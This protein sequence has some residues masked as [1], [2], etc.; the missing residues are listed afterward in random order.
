MAWFVRESRAERI[1]DK[2]ELYKKLEAWEK[3][4]EAIISGLIDEYIQRHRETAELLSRPEWVEV[5]CNG[6]KEVATGL[7]GKMLD[8]LED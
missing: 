5:I 7:K 8:E 2:K 1:K 4:T 6:K 3:Q